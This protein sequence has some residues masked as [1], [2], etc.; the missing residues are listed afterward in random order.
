MELSRHIQNRRK[1]ATRRMTIIFFL[2]LIP[3]VVFLIYA[4]DFLK[5]RKTTDSAQSQEV[6][7]E[8][9]YR[10][11]GQLQFRS[12]ENDSITTILIEIADTPQARE[13]GLMYRFYMPE[14]MGMLFIYTEEQHLGYWMKN[15]HIPLDILYADKDFRI[16]SIYENTSPQSE[17][18]LPSRSKAKHVIEVNGGFVSR[19]GIKAGDYF[20]YSRNVK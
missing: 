6:K 8:N 15:T 19:H 9:L 3:L 20:S 16:L 11:D 18:T 7:L 5:D 1:P 2:F 13:R 14:N 17:E 4:M 10:I 12:S